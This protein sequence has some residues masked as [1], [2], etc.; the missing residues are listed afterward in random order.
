MINKLIGHI[1]NHVIID[2]EQTKQLNSNL[3][4]AH[5][6]SQCSHESGYFRYK[7]E[8]LNYSSDALQ[9]VFK[10]YFPTKDLADQYSRQPEKIANRV[11]ANRMGNGEEM[12]GDGWRYRGRGY[13][14]LTGKD[15]Y[16]D[17]AKYINENI[18]PEDVADSYSVLSAIYFFDKNN[19]WEIC[20]SGSDADTVIRL[21]KRINGGLN[22]L[23]HRL[24][25][26]KKYFDCLNKL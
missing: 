19:L 1:P 22:G 7:E 3:R 12:S 25:L 15:N 16:N 23:D 20:D 6:I 5:F 13:I 4:I 24:Q 2:L 8:N 17:F 21:T 26:F 10:K 9:I 18:N 11:Y 14:Q